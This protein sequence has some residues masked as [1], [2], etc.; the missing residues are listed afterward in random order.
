MGQIF[1]QVVTLIVNYIQLYSSAESKFSKFFPAWKKALRT[2]DKKENEGRE[3][4][5]KRKENVQK[6]LQ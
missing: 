3:E 5:E 6:D 1:T 4:N 2:K